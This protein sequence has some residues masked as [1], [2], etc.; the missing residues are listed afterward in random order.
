MSHIYSAHHGIK[1]QDGPIIVAN[2]GEIF[3]ERQ[4]WNKDKK[5]LEPTGKYS[6]LN[7]RSIPI[8]QYK[9]KGIGAYTIPEK[10]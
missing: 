6:H 10:H 4:R 8:K 2:D 3:I 9:E 1:L 7:T 5:I